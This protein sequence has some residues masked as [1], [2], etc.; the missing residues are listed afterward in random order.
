MLEFFETSEVIL[1]SPPPACQHLRHKCLAHGPSSS[2]IRINSKSKSSC[3]NHGPSHLT[4]TSY[5][6]VA[7]PSSLSSQ[8]SL[9]A[10]LPRTQELL[11]CHPTLSNSAP[12]QLLSN[13]RLSV[14]HVCSLPTQPHPVHSLLLPIHCSLHFDT[15]T[16][17]S[18]LCA[19]H[20]CF[21]H[22]FHN[23]FRSDISCCFLPPPEI[24]L[25][26]GFSKMSP[27]TVLQSILHVFHC[28]HGVLLFLVMTDPM[29]LLT[30]SLICSSFCLLVS[31]CFMSRRLQCSLLRQSTPWHPCCA[32]APRKSSCSVLL[33]HG[34]SRLVCLFPELRDGASAFPSS[35]ALPLSAA[36]SI[37][38]GGRSCLLFIGSPGTLTGAGGGDCTSS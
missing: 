6:S 35:L 33:S 5:V 32:L 31:A 19:P 18:R 37:G 24:I 11:F 14:L 27:V 15:L 20:R 7:S 23:A 8:P 13:F 22:W 26:V 38:S 28:H 36:R 29:T 17:P 34:T 3:H 10:P 4:G 21:H 12:C 9:H 25:S 1:L 2:S 16:G 30:E